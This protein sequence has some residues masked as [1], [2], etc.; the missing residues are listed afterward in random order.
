[1]QLIIG[2]AHVGH[3]D[4]IKRGVDMP[5]FAQKNTNVY[6][7]NYKGSNMCKILQEQN[8]N[9]SMKFQFEGFSFISG[10][11]RDKAIV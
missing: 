6:C 4:I 1:M 2:C 10:I 3:G 8:A 7:N 11:L 5:N 9:S